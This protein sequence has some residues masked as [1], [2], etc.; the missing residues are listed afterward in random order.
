MSYVN[1]KRKTHKSMG[2]AQLGMVG[3]SGAIAKKAE[4]PEDF[5][6]QYVDIS[7]KR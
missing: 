2:R 7:T 3:L 1:G 4:K 6:T 5:S